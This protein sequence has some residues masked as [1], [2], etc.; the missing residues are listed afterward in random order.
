MENNSLS[1]FADEINDLMPLLLREFGRR[2]AKELCKNKITFPQFFLLDYLN[3]H[4]SSTMTTLA[5][6]MGVTTAAMTGIIERLVESGYCQRVYD[7]NDRRLIRMKIASSGQRIV[8][9]VNQERRRM[10]IDIFS[11]LPSK[12][13]QD[14]LRSLRYIHETITSK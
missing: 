3:K 5:K 12:I 14:Y 1:K 2:Q 13:R 8:K 9:K 11:K 4:G 7:A 6:F 10:I